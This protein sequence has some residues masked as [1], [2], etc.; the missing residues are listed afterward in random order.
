MA[1][2]DHNFLPL[3]EAGGT[4]REVARVVNQILS[5][6]LNCKGSF[7]AASGSHKVKD[8]RCGVNSVVLLSPRSAA[9]AGGFVSAKNKHEFTV[10]GAAG[11]VFDYVVIG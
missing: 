9:A 8:F 10:D 2:K 11:G 1:T 4:P 5:G 3:P 6:K 7:T